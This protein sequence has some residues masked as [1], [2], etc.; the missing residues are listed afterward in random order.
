VFVCINPLL[1]GHQA[2]HILTDS[3]AT[4]LITSKRDWARIREE[5]KNVTSLRC[6]LLIDG[7]SEQ[8]S[9][10]VDGIP[11]AYAVMKLKNG[12]PRETTSIGEDLAGLL[13][14]SGSTGKP[15]GVMLSHRNLLAG[16]R[17]VSRY[18]GI[19][20][21]E[22]ILSIL[23]F[24]FDYG[25]NQLLTSVQNRSSIVLFQYRFPSELVKTL[26]SESITGLAGVPLV[27]AGLTHHSSGLA[28]TQLTTLRYVTNSGGSVPTPTVKALRQLL[29]GTQ[30]FL[31][32]GLTEA[33]RATYLP[34][35]Q[36]DFRPNSIGKAIPETEILVIGSD[37]KPCRPGESGI[38]VQ[39][40]PT[41]S[42]GY[43]NNPEK[44]REVLRPHP[45]VPPERGGETV[46]YSGD[47]VK[48]DEEGFLYF[49]ARA[50]GQIK[51]QGYRISPT[52]I[53][54]VLMQTADLAEVAVIGI[55]DSSTGEQVHAIV[56]PAA[57]D[58]FDV[59]DV[60]RR[61][62]QRLPAYMAPKSLDVVASLPR[63]PNG[64]VD[65]QLLRAQKIGQQP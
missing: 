52:E 21:S 15:R 33:F 54:E 55:P 5:A 31:M 60:L 50:D 17:I 25:L 3:G 30:I 48:M 39:R 65:Y 10:V 36:V 49:V 29:P 27:W 38:L 18:L 37:G 26:K 1:L 7:K 40:G 28:T 43:W 44:T 59:P 2:A 53:E 46:C 58:S 51:S 12:A 35:D 24:S 42:L 22:R 41:V 4:Y 16:S 14:T 8:D 13:Y 56:V 62:A 45:F 64:K 34:P 57:A 47:V 19:G 20:R 63:T 11:A 61:C 32:Y 6:V 23:P 9:E